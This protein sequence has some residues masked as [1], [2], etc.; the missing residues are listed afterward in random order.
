MSSIGAVE[1]PRTLA[2]VAAIVVPAVPGSLPML[3]GSLLIDAFVVSSLTWR[4]MPALTRI[5]RP[6]LQPRIS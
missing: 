6:W 1:S 2:H 3:A 5:F 4:F